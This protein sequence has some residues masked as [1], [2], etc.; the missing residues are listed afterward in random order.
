[1]QDEGQ[2]LGVLEAVAVHGDGFGADDAGLLLLLLPPLRSAL[3]A[4]RALL[5]TSAT[6]SAHAATA[7]LAPPAPLLDAGGAV[8][9]GEVAQL[10]R[11]IRSAA[12]QLTQATRCARDT[13]GYK[14]GR[15]GC[16]KLEHGG[17]QAGTHMA[18]V[19]C[20]Y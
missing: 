11:Q 20:M 9:G 6:Q 1:M 17:S 16:H 15:I 7:L 3:L 19:L 12:L 8:S 18:A 5:S 13:Y 2:P 10:L 4:R 14:V